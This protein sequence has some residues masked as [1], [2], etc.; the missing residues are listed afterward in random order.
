[1][2]SFNAPIGCVCFGNS[3][4]PLVGE[5]VSPALAFYFYGGFDIAHDRNALRSRWLFSLSV[6][7]P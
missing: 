6:K 1:M 7:L 3:K 5:P 2:N 4:R